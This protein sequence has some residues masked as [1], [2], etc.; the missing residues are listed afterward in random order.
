[1]TTTGSEQATS[2]EVEAAE[3]GEASPGAAPDRRPAG[4]SRRGIRQVVRDTTYKRIGD[5]R[6]RAS[7]S[8]ET[9]ASAV[10]E[11]T[12]RLREGGQTRI[13][14]YTNRAADRLERWSSQLRQ[15]DIDDVVRRVLDFA[16]REP[17]MFLGLSFAT[18]LI[19]ARFLK[20]SSPAEAQRLRFATGREHPAMRTTDPGGRQFGTARGS[21]S[22][23]TDVASREGLHP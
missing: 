16:R 8:L 13:A 12:D 11:L 22:A 20:S 9:I 6:D 10:R 7:E 15:Q 5:Q 19:I 17:A 2:R 14:D 1:M 4:G 23:G 21:G 3:R 18:G